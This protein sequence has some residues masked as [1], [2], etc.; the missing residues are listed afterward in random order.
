ML[1]VITGYLDKM[2]DP[3]DIS[4]HFWKKKKNPPKINE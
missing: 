3:K 2:T 4:K 1:V